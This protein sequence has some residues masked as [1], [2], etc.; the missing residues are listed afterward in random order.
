[1]KIIV[2]A[3]WHFGHRNMEKPE[4]GG[5]PANFEELIA[6]NLL[7][8]VNQSEDSCVLLCLGDVAVGATGDEGTNALLAS[9]PARVKRWLIR[10]NH[11]T[12]SLGWYLTHGWDAVADA[13]KLELYGKKILFSHSSADDLGGAA[14]N[15]HGHL[16][17]YAYQ[18]DE[19]SVDDGGRRILISPEYLDYRPIEL[20]TLLRIGRT[21]EFAR[22][23]FQALP[24]GGIGTGPTDPSMLSSLAS[25]VGKTARA[26]H[27]S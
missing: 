17:K 19:G 21:P 1:M 7:S 9:M 14:L 4:F 11:D 15:V 8:L 2:T 18:P 16:H 23:H 13:M 6:K 3:D 27:E 10:G 24:V 26:L 12:R 20:Q 22:G 5:R 25:Y